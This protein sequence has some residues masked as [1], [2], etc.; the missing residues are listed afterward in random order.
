[1][2]TVLLNEK[3][4]YNVPITENFKENGKFIVRGIAINSTT[5]RNGITYEVE[6]LEIAA[7]T[8]RNRPV[9]KD[10]INSVDNIVGRTT[11]NITFNSQGK[12]VPFEADIKDPVMQQKIQSGLVTNVSIGAMVKDIERKE[13]AN[14][15]EINVAKGIEFVE[16]SLV[17]VPGDPGAGFTHALNEK[18]NA[19]IVTEKKILEETKMSEKNEDIKEEKVEK[20]E[21]SNNKEIL[22]LK[23]EL[24][25]IKQ[26]RLEKLYEDYK[27]LCEKVGLEA[28]EKDSISEEGFKLL[29]NSYKEII[30]K[31]ESAEEVEEEKT[32]EEVEEEPEAEEETEAEEPVKEEEMKADVEI[33]KEEAK[34]EV[35]GFNFEQGSISGYAFYATEESLKNKNLKRMIR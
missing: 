24:K 26:E 18:L 13:D 35:K 25:Q 7:P 27:S 34:D 12:F 16:L 1:M 15:K 30:N 23:E 2:E 33:N 11:N 19:K 20:T 29:I 21:T 4:N 6:D 22:S 8:L 5:T 3:I 28:K 10:H 31:K 17:A 32:A 9:L 14:G